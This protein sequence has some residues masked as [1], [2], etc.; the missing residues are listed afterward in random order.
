MQVEHTPELSSTELALIWS[1]YIENS[2]SIQVL[3][4]FNSINQD[5]DIAPAIN[6]SLQ[7][8]QETVDQLAELFKKE[9]IPVPA[10]FTQEELHPNAPRLYSDVYALRYMKHM[11]K[12][13][14]STYAMATAASAR[15]DVSSLFQKNL[16]ETLKLH[17]ENTKIML[18]KGIYIRPPILTKPD[19]VEFVT[20]QT[21]MQ[22]LIGRKRPLTAIEICHM[23]MNIENNLIGSTLLT[24]FAQVAQN[25]KVR[26]YMVRGKQIGH[27][28]A[29]VL[30]KHL[31]DDEIASP[32]V[33]D[34]TIERSIT[35]PFSDKLMLY[36]T[37]ALNS[38]GIGNYGLAIAASLRNDLVMDYTRL[39][40]EVLKYA[41]D[42][43]NLMI[44][45]GWLEQ[46]PQATDFRA[47]S[48]H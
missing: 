4:H 32:S 2:L 35:P 27:K 23:S 44:D 47:L 46:P 15:T 45:E 36:H 37:N 19:K 5:P 39:M 10:G 40:T 33:W 17:N 29:E 48:H 34:S 20:R 18:E 14:L 13:G 22:G 26:E 24:G 38:F 3:T 12:I 25:P 11:T 28:H 31:V 6:N 42:G 16:E 8:S 1:T 30:R 41:E 21:F 7:L 9:S 43:A